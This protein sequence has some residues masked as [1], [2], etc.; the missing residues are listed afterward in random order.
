[1]AKMVTRTRLDVTFIRTLRILIKSVAAAS[2]QS[3]LWCEHNEQTWWSQLQQEQQ[4]GN[5][6]TDSTTHPQAAQNQIGR[7]FAAQCVKIIMKPLQSS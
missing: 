7:T 3:R 2:F 6:E 5:D 1:M 4:P